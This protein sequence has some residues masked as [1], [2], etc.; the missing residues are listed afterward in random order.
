MSAAVIAGF[1]AASLSVRCAVGS[2]GSGSA[3]GALLLSILIMWIVG[4]ATTAF[5]AGGIAFY[6][7]GLAELWWCD[8]RRRKERADPR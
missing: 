3:S 6:G 5:G 2:L 4:I 7:L 1:V 8:R